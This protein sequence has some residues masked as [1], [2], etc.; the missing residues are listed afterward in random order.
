MH[1][2]HE[3]IPVLFL[4]APSGQEVNLLSDS[5]PFIPF[6]SFPLPLFLLSISQ[7]CLENNFKY[8]RK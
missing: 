6:L 8:R 1:C 2:V 7:Q 5:I 3:F 4:S